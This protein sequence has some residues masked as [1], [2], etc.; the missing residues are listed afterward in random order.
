MTIPGGPPP[1]RRLT[2]R[3]RCLS[4][5]M[6]VEAQALETAVYQQRLAAAVGRIRRK[7]IAIRSLLK[8]LIRTNPYRGK[9]VPDRAREAR[10]LQLAVRRALRSL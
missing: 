5:E 8:R 2:R 9:P 10:L 4:R 6:L 1:W 7:L 3:L